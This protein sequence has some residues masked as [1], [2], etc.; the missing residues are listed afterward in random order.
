MQQKYFEEIEALKKEVGMILMASTS[1][2][3]LRLIDNLDRLGLAFH[4]EIEIEHKLK[5]VYASLEAD[6]NSDSDSDLFTTALR[7]RLLRHHRYHVSTS[8]SLFK[9]IIII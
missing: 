7:F 5:Q 1:T 8:K 9:K 3:L 4:F 2:K 6:S